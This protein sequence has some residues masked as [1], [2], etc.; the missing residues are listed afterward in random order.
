MILPGQAIL[1]LVSFLF[2]PSVWERNERVCVTVSGT[3]LVV[4]PDEHC[5]TMSSS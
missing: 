2:S 1:H 5:Q 4:S 3:P